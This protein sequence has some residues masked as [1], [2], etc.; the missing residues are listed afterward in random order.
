MKESIEVLEKECEDW[1]EDNIYHLRKNRYMSSD[2]R[3][4]LVRDSRECC[5]GTAVRVF[6]RNSIEP[7]SKYKWALICLHLVKPM[8]TR[9]KAIVREYE[10][11][12]RDA[13]RNK[14]KK[15]ES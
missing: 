7:A 5:F 13:D 9:W 2:V 14:K 11:E 3:E 4:E 12:H 1:L 15:A 8:I 6:F 10:K